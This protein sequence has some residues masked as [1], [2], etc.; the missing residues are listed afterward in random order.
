[1]LL[2]MGRTSPPS[3][4]YLPAKDRMTIGITKAWLIADP[5]PIA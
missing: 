3:K 4:E 1:M 5:K 2:S